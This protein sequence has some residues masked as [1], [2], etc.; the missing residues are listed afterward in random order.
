MNKLKK[1]AADYNRIRTI[2]DLQKRRLTLSEYNTLEYIIK[3]LCSAGKSRFCEK[4]ILQYL[5]KFDIACSPDGIG[6]IAAL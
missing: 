1:L 4:N 2:K 6:W 5:K 3:D